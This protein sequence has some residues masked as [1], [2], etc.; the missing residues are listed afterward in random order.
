LIGV[1]SPRDISD[2]QMMKKTENTPSSSL[3]TLPVH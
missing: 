3:T 1:L 2:Y